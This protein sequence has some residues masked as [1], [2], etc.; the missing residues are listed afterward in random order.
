MPRYHGKQ[1]TSQGTSVSGLRIDINTRNEGG[2]QIFI[3]ILHL[4]PGTSI[5]VC[6]VFMG[7][8]CYTLVQTFF[9]NTRSL[10]LDQAE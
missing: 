4:N 2:I 8:Q 1:L 9:L 10:D 7:I 3:E 5:E 6:G